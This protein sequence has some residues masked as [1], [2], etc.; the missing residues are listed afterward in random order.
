MAKDELIEHFF[1]FMEA[2]QE[3]ERKGEKEFICPLCGGKARWDRA[4]CNGH[5][6]SLCTACG[7]SVDE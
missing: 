5:K 4:S 1:K 6:H 7:F 3:A 2:M